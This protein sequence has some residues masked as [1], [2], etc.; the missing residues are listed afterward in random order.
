VLSGLKARSRRNRGDRFF[1]LQSEAGPSSRS[2]SGEQE[3]RTSLTLLTASV[4]REK[5]AATMLEGR[6]P[7]TKPTWV[8]LERL[9][10]AHLVTLSLCQSESLGIC[11]MQIGVRATVAA[12]LDEPEPAQY[13]VKTGQSSANTWRVPSQPRTARWK[14]RIS[15]QILLRATFYRA[16]PKGQRS[17]RSIKPRRISGSPLSA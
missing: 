9:D 3:G 2:R 12:L 11:S 6:H 14:P 8:S 13:D 1:G 7:T 4:G 10:Q 16:S 5:F 17:S 15:P